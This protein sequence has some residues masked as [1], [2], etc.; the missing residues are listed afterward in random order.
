MVTHS[1]ACLGLSGSSYNDTSTAKMVFRWYQQ[2]GMQRLCTPSFVRAHRMPS[3]RPVCSPFVSASMTPALSRYFLKASLC[4]SDCAMLC[5]AF[6][7]Q[8]F[9]WAENVSFWKV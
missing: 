5:A 8:M 4:M 3:A 9:D 6:A 1:T 7:Q 2:A